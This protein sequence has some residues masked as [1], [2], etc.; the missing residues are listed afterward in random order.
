MGRGDGPE[1]RFLSRYRDREME[2]KKRKVESN[3]KRHTRSFIVVY[4]WLNSEE[5]AG[6]GVRGTYI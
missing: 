3:R 1:F 5:E 4:F 6:F 2:W